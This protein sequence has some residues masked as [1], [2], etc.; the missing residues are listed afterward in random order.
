MVMNF[1][2]HI[3]IDYSGRETP[4]SR[5]P[6]LQ[7]YADSDGEEPEAIRTPKNPDGGNWNWCRKEIAEWLI[8]QAKSKVKFIAGI[9]H[10]FSFPLNYF[11][12]HKLKSWNAFLDDFC[13]HW[14]TDDDHTNVDF[15]REKAP[16]RTGFIRVERLVSWVKTCERLVTNSQGMERQRGLACRVA[17]GPSRFQGFRATQLANFPRLLPLGGCFCTPEHRCPTFARRSTRM[18]LEQVLPLTSD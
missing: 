2:L 15:I 6:C 18:N 11:Q 16:D 14:P 3:G 10:G 5:T 12:K 17:G 9:D 13:K 8:D 1:D 7:V 4:T